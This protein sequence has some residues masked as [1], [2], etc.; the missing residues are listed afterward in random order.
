VRSCFGWVSRD[1]FENGLDEP[2]NELKG[3]F[4]DDGFENYQDDKLNELKKN[5]SRMLSE[6][7]A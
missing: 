1:D 6:G 3:G 5:K 2:S 7:R 4:L